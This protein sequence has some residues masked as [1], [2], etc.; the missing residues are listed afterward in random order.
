VFDDAIGGGCPNKPRA[1]G[2]QLFR[3][4]TNPRGFQQPFTRVT[5]PQS[6][7]QGGARPRLTGSK[8]FTYFNILPRA[9]CAPPRAQAQGPPPEELHFRFRITRNPRAHT[10]A[11]LGT[12]AARYALPQSDAFFHIRDILRVEHPTART[13]L[14]PTPNE[15]VHSHQEFHDALDFAQGTELIAC[16]FG[17]YLQRPL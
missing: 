16:G 4:A 9:H 6:A 3:E 2:V 15:L 7:R 12:R 10:S 13:V 5:P 1:K 17:V 14:R 8:M 11:P